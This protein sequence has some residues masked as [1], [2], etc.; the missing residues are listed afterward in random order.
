MTQHC[1]S[2][3]DLDRERAAA[4]VDRALEMKRNDERSDLLA[5]KTAALLFEK[6]STR[7]RLSFEVAVRHLG[8]D[9]LFMTPR[10]T[11]LGR[12]EPIQDTARVLSRYV[13]LVVARVFSQRT[14]EDL[15]RFGTVPVINALSDR[16]HP[17]QLL[18]DVMTLRERFETMDDLVVAWLGDGNNMA[19]S[20]C[21][22]A[23]LFGFELRLACPEGFDPEEAVL[24][25]SREL[26]A[27]IHLTRD[28]AEAAAGA[29][30]VTTDVWVSMGQEE[31]ASRTREVFE[32]YQVNAAL[33]ATADPAAVFLH[34]LPAHRGEEVTEEVLEG[35]DSA[36]WDEAENRL[37]AQKALIEHL[38]V[39]HGGAV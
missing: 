27:R 9:A 4:V 10:E 16:F 20:W 15:A 11:Q 36:V 23:A 7:T 25:T 35:P 14:L 34:C 8:G 29:H 5:G 31:E 17:C 19:N 38:F 33:M 28:P 6:A 32:P 2:L 37:H 24:R 22:A 21:N 30:C 1:L 3:L 12:N 26:G 39:G 13:D 18:A